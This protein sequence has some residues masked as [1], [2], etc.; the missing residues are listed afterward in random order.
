MAHSNVTPQKYLEQ[1]HECFW[2]AAQENVLHTHG[3]FVVQKSDSKSGPRCGE[4][5]KSHSRKPWKNDL[6]TAAMSENMMACEGNK[7]LQGLD[8]V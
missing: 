4:G 8:Q 2:G 5:K 1:R 3:R 7:R 6:L